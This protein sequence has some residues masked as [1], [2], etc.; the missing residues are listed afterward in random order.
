MTR[1]FS[2]NLDTSLLILIPGEQASADPT[3]LDRRGERL[4]PLDYLEMPRITRNNQLLSGC[5]VYRAR[6][7]IA[8]PKVAANVL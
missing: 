6:E 7:K 1:G 5:A 4:S 2:S 8:L 3:N